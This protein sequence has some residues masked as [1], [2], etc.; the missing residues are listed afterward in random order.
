MAPRNTT[1]IDKEDAALK[2][3]EGNSRRHSDDSALQTDKRRRFGATLVPKRATLSIDWCARQ[4][5][6]SSSSM[7]RLIKENKK[8]EK[9]M[10]KWAKMEKKRIRTLKSSLT[11]VESINDVTESRLEEKMDGSNQA[12]G[13]SNSLQHPKP[14]IERNASLRLSDLEE[15]SELSEE[16]S[17]T[18]MDGS[19]LSEEQ[20]RESSH[21]SFNYDNEDSIGLENIGLQNRSQDG[22]SRRRRSIDQYDVQVPD[23]FVDDISAMGATVITACADDK[24]TRAI[25]VPNQVR[26]DNITTAPSTLTQSWPSPG[27]QTPPS[28]SPD[29]EL[30]LEDVEKMKQTRSMTLPTS[31]VT[32]QRKGNHR[33]STLL[34]TDTAQNAS[35][36]ANRGLMSRK[37]MK[38]LKKEMK[39]GKP[40]P[41]IDLD[42]ISLGSDISGMDLNQSNDINDCSAEEGHPFSNYT[43][44]DEEKKIDDTYAAVRGSIPKLSSSLHSGSKVSFRKRVS[45]IDDEE[46]S[47]EES[48]EKMHVTIQVPKKFGDDVSALEFD[49][50]ASSR[51][52]KDHW[53]K[54]SGGCLNDDD[55]SSDSEDEAAES[56]E[57]VPHPHQHVLPL[58]LSEQSLGNDESDANLDAIERLY[59]TPSHDR[60]TPEAGGQSQKRQSILRRNTL[61]RISSSSSQKRVS[62]NA[63]TYD[64]RESSVEDSTHPNASVSSL[65][66]CR[67]TNPLQFGNEVIEQ[68]PPVFDLPNLT[69]DKDI[70]VEKRVSVAKSEISELTYEDIEDAVHHPNLPGGDIMSGSCGHVQNHHMCHTIGAP[71]RAP[72]TDK[73]TALLSSSLQTGLDNIMCATAKSLTDGVEEERNRA[74][75]QLIQTVLESKREVGLS[76]DEVNVLHKMVKRLSDDQDGESDHSTASASFEESNALLEEEHVPVHNM[77]SSFNSAGTLKVTNKS[78]SQAEMLAKVARDMSASLERSR[79]N[80]SKQESSNRTGTTNN[81][82]Q[83]ALDKQNQ[84]SKQPQIPVKRPPAMQPP[85]MQPSLAREEFPQEETA[86]PVT[87]TAIKNTNHIPGD[88]STV[89]DVATNTKHTLKDLIGDNNKMV[90][91]PKDEPIS[92][93]R[94]SMTSSSMIC[95]VP[96]SSGQEQLQQFKALSLPHDKSDRKMEANTSRPVTNTRIDSYEDILTMGMNN[97][98]VTMLVNI[99]GRLRE[100]SLLGHASVRLRDIDVNSHQRNSRMKGLKRLK[101]LKPEDENKGYLETTLTAGFIVRAAIDEYEMFESSPF[102]ENCALSQ[103]KKASI[104]YDTTMVSDFKAWVAESLTKNFDGQCFEEGSV[105]RDLVD[106]SLEVVW[107]SDRHPIDVNYCICVNRMASRVIVVFRGDEGVLRRVKDSTMMDHENPLSEEL[108]NT[109]FIKLRAAVSKDILTPRLDTKMSIVEEIHDRV[110]KIRIEL[111]GRDPCHVTI[112][113]H[114][115]GGGL[116]TVTGFY[117]ACNNDLKLASPIQIVTFASPRVGGKEFQRSFQH[118]EDSGRIL[119]ARFTNLNDMISLRPFWA[120]SGSWKFEDWYKHVGMHIC[121]DTRSIQGFDLDYRRITGLPDELWNLIKS[122]FCGNSKKSSILEYHRRMRFAKKQYLI[123]QK[124]LSKRKRKKLITLE[125]CYALHESFNEF[126]GDM[127]GSSSSSLLKLVLVAFFIVIEIGLLLRIMIWRWQK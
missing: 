75:A 72:P 54:N 71:G 114:N 26:D 93:H 83:L 92:Q 104:D 76:P 8:E 81:I 50:K 1:I 78:K 118:L 89:R 40:K 127:K 111:T 18:I 108:G 110:N 86:K 120:I 70:Q 117:L 101:L 21:A 62:F 16:P 5:L 63:R 67:H 52:L 123:Q 66:P 41:M 36:F 25:P 30:K 9:E 79:S 105:M 125:E 23:Q 124:R 119:Y 68:Q 59:K 55:F 113:G 27:R 56:R 95:L 74:F 6:M 100:M 35:W 88:D 14:T 53:A 28:S 90:P 22:L 51:S 61:K 12:P 116:A 42:D 33:Q 10:K 112:C 48:E 85:A 99:Y 84:P 122:Y 2:E 82:V 126:D 94:S 38:L 46:L 103:V 19:N 60:A 58:Q 57:V 107:I 69:Q 97:L 29:K 91:A 20:R 115:L 11:S 87:F 96:P 45:E 49:W 39:K 43:I 65:T 32:V 15:E 44:E 64:Q 31:A 37:S 13:M 102:N 24:T 121:L 34:P 106:S 109:E 80:R 3:E 73:E 17:S 47:L 4:G 98:S 77:K 7:R